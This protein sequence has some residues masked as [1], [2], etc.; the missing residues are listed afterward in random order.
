MKG[1]SVTTSECDATL[2]TH[3]LWYIMSSMVTVTVEVDTVTLADAVMA[4]SDGMK[5]KD[6][7]IKTLHGAKEVLSLMPSGAVWAPE[8]Q[9]ASAPV[10]EEK[11]AAKRRKKAA[12]KVDAVSETET[13]TE[14]VVDV[15]SKEVEMDGVALMKYCNGEFTK[16]SPASARVAKV[17][18][19]AAMFR[20]EFGVSSVKEI[21]AD[22]IAEAKAKFNTIM[23]GK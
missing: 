15:P 19:V 11:P 14:T 1:I 16:I 17:K 6:A 3:L 12:P 8:F 2:A 7:E 13:E 9:K 22:K 23:E 5:T 21:P 18:K 20:E 4:I 10:V